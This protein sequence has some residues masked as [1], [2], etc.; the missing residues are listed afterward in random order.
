MKSI[1]IL[2]T[3]YDSN[4]AYTAAW[5][6]ALHGD[7]VKQQ[8]I[9]C[10]LYEAQ[11]LC[12]S[13]TALADAVERSD[14]VVFYGHGMQDRWIALPELPGSS[15]GVAAIPVVD[16]SSVAVLQGRKVYAG[17]CWSLNGLGGGYIAKFPNGEY[18]GYRHEFGFEAAN[19]AYFK[20]VVNQ[21]VIGFVNGDPANTVANDLRAEWTSLRTRFFSGNLRT[22]RNAPM[23]AKMA[24]LNSQRIGSQP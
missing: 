6:R 4:S 2:S 12:R 20:D 18:V 19:E 15:P 7:L 16:T 3:C 22:R 5:A 9:S 11:Y 23:A 8:D 17:C 1:L 21:S 13:S 14:F 24:D 10:F